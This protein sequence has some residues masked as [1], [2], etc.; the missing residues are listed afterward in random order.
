MTHLQLFLGNSD[1]DEAIK[2]LLDAWITD[3]TNIH[4]EYTS[5]HNNPSA[6]VR[7]GIKD[8]PALVWQDEIIVQGPTENWVLPLL[9]RVFVAQSSE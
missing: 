3:K 6:V 7:L 5:I 4:L 2:H 1:R 8:L 9:D